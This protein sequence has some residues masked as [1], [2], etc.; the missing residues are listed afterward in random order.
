MLHFDQVIS[1][2]SFIIPSGRCAGMQQLLGRMK[3]KLKGRGI[4]NGNGKRR[5]TWRS[6]A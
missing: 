2:T 6:Y 4:G 1:D 3:M 5:W